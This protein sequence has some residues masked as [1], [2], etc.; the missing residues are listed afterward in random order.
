[1]AREHVAGATPPFEYRLIAGGR[2]NLTYDVSDGAGGR[3]VLRRPP[4]GNVLESRTTWA[5]STA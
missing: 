3:F 1:M 2:S 4:L 5:A